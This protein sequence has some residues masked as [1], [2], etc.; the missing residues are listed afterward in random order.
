M[1]KLL[2]ALVASAQLSTASAA[3]PYLHMFDNG[4]PARADSL[5]NLLA[6]ALLSPQRVSVAIPEPA[7]NVLLIFGLV[8]IG[9]L[10]IFL[11]KKLG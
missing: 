4:M 7:T 6:L 9:G 8:T 3:L 5:T 10:A 1:R 2:P 11:G